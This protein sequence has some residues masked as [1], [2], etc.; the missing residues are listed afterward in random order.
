MNNI[1]TGA[2]IRRLRLEHGLTQ[3]VLAERLCVGDKTVSKWERGLGCPDVALL[4]R[5]AALFDVPVSTLLAGELPAA[6]RDSGNMKKVRFFVCPACGS[7][8]T[9]TGA[10][11]VTCCGRRLTPLTPVRATPEQRLRVE[12]IDGMWYVSGD[13]PMR[14]DDYVRFIAFATDARL[15]FCRQYPEGALEARIPRDR[16]GVLYWYAPDA[17][18]LMQYV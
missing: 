7:I 10:A 16:H 2:L 14:K 11:E 6:A 3:R 17:G 5:L 1:R 8:M 12:E 15:V 13:H 9:G 18:L 4:D